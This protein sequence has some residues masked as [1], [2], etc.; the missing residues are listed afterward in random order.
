MRDAGGR[1]RRGLGGGSRSGAGGPGPGGSSSIYT[2]TSE[3]AGGLFDNLLF[4]IHNKLEKNQI[5]QYFLRLRQGLGKESQ[6][7]P[8]GERP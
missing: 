1:S 7:M 5:V 6:G 2:V 4:I 3:A 8:N